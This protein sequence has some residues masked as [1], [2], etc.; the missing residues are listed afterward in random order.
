[1]LEQISPEEPRDLSA[2]VKRVRED[3]AVHPEDQEGAGGVEWSGGKREKE[4]SAG[5][6]AGERGGT[7]PRG[8]EKH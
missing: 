3:P 7:V 4:E 2:G 6:E 1:M 5:T 8:A